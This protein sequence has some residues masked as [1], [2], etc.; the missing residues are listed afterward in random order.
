MLKTCRVVVSN[1][2]IDNHSE[3]VNVQ[4]K[5]RVIRCS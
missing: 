4:I 3:H 1:N 5:R 2:T